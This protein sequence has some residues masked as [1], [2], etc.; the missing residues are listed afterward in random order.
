MDFDN[1]FIGMTLYGWIAFI[2]YLLSVAA[3]VYPTVRDGNRDGT[4]GCLIFFSIIPLVNTMYGMF[5]FV[6]MFEDW[7][8]RRTDKF[9]EEE[10]AYRTYLKYTENTKPTVLPTKTPEKETIKE[11]QKTDDDDTPITFI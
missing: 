10:A 9:L 8:Q 11:I 1:P 4:L 7:D 5:C 3:C 2:G 6:K